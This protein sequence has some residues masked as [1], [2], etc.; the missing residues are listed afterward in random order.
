MISGYLHRKMD[1][2]VNTEDNVTQNK[3]D[4]AISDQNL[5]T[6]QT[7]IGKTNLSAHTEHDVKDCSATARLEE[8]KNLPGFH[9][10]RVDMG[11]QHMEPPR[12]KKIKL[13]PGHAASHTLEPTDSQEIGKRKRIQHDYRRLS[14]AGY[15]DDYET[16]RERRFSSDSDTTP[17]TVVRQKSLT[18]GTTD[19]AVAEDL[20]PVKLTLKLS[21]TENGTFING[22]G[23]H[24]IFL[25]MNL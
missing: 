18:S 1:D 24:M 21:K 13:S 4:N 5:D 16:S 15:L 22:N 10:T 17:P 11:D 19:N 12:P 25:I 7:P 3:R 23:M 14:S 20:P 8:R 6:K 9:T 2:S